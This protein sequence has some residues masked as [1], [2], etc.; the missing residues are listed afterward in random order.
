MVLPRL[1]YCFG[2]MAWNYFTQKKGMSTRISSEFAYYG[3]A[4]IVPLAIIEL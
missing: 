2:I 1:W 3:W 4:G